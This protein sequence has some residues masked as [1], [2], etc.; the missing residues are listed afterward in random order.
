LE[1]LLLFVAEADLKHLV[2]V[3]A[4]I[5]CGA[6]AVVLCW[7]SLVVAA[8]S[9]AQAPVRSAK[10]VP[11]ITLTH[12]GVTQLAPVVYHGF[13]SDC[14]VAV[15]SKSCSPPCT[16]TS[17][18]ETLIPWQGKHLTVLVDPWPARAPAVMTEL[19]SAL[20]RASSYYASTTGRVPAPAYSLNG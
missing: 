6:G 17:C 3:R 9:G 10:P 18:S 11:P 4:A 15:T 7:A 19:V 12:G 14:A 1:A 2:R 5:V 8:P 16:S 20:D 13:A